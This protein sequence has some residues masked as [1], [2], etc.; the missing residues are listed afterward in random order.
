MIP[1]DNKSFNKTPSLFSSKFDF[2]K[3]KIEE[4]RL[5]KLQHPSWWTS[6]WRGLIA[7]PEAKHRK[8]MGSAV[9]MYLYLLV[10]ANRKTGIV[11]RPQIAMHI[12]TGYPIRTIQ[13]QLFKQKKQGYITTEHSGRYLKITILKWKSFHDPNRIVTQKPF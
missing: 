6:L 2:L 5:A 12:D 11:R 13:S 10:Y 8:A 1:Q 3:K 9:W 7:D 4:R